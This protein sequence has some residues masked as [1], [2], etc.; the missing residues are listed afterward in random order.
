MTPDLVLRGA[1][2]SAIAPP[3]IQLLTQFNATPNVQPGQQTVTLT[4]NNPNL[5]PETGFGYDIGAD[6]RFHKVYYVSG[7]IYLTNVFNQFISSTYDSGLVCSP[8]T[9]PGSN[10]PAQGGPEV[11]YQSNVN[12][13]STRYEGLELSLRRVVPQGLGF[14]LSGSTQ[15]GYAYNLP[16]NFYCSFAVTASTPCNPST[17]NTNLA[18]I[19]SANFSGGN[20]TLN[21]GGNGVSNQSVP[22]LQGYGELNYRTRNGWYASFGATVF[23]KNNSYSE[24]PFAVVRASLRAPITD[25]LA[26]QISGNNIFNAYNGLFPIVGGGVGIPLAN[27]ALGASN[28]NVLGPAT[29]NFILTKAFGGSVNDNGRS[30]NSSR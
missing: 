27:G 10:C 4:R 7:D 20:G 9:F 14:T 29:W 17:Y 16:R 19:P 26:V 15:R 5:V 11:F 24:P 22:Y 21:P 28:G 12:L 25:T 2:G 23:G 30:T 3:Y 6:Y 1:A 13:T 18:I 8:S